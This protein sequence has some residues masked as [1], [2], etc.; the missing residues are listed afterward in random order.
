L[1]TSYRSIGN[2]SAAL[3]HEKKKNGA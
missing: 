1:R 2:P 3:L